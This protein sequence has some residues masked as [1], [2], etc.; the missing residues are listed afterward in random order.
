LRTKILKKK[1]KLKLINLS[2]SNFLSFFQYIFRTTIELHDDV[3]KGIDFLGCEYNKDGDSYRSPWSNKYYP[4]IEDPSYSPFYPTGKLLEMETS[5]NE[6]FARYAKLYYDKDF[7][8]SVYFFESGADNA[9]GSCW[10]VKKTVK[11]GG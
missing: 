6:V 3:E 9:F 7:I 10:L 5:A 11:G 1:F 2:V 8:T 4:T